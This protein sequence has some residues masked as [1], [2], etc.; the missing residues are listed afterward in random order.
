[1][2]LANNEIVANDAVIA[3]TVYRF[4]RKPGITAFIRLKDEAASLEASLESI[5]GLFDAYVILIQPSSDRTIEICREFATAEAIVTIIHYPFESWPNGPGYKLQDPTSIRSRTF[6]YN[7]GCRFI[8][9]EFACKWDGDM[10]AAEGL[11]YVLDRFRSGRKKYLAFSG[12]ECADGICS[13]HLD[14]KSTPNEVRV[15]PVLKRNNFYNGD[16]CERHISYR[17]LGKAHRKLF[18][19]VVDEPV[20]YHFKHAKSLYS[21]TKAW[22]ENWASIEHFRKLLDVKVVENDGSL[23]VL[24]QSV[25]REKNGL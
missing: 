15:F 11:D 9:T 22:P 6:Y 19:E 4:D 7:F 8:E 25:L 23:P 10:I 12:I 16:Y 18:G 20:Y 13:T 21:K 24:T 2:S 17:G 1:M 14:R 5:R 3:K